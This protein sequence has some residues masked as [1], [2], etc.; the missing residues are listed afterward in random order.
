MTGQRDEE[1]KQIITDGMNLPYLISSYGRVI[2]VNYRG[3]EFNPKEMRTRIGARGYLHVSLSHH[4]A[5]KTFLVHRL[6][7]EAFI[8]NPENKPIVN[9]ID[10]VPHHCFIWNLEWVTASENT[11]HAFSIGRMKVRRGEEIGDNKFTTPM[12]RR[13][14]ELLS[15]GTHT[16]LEISKTTG[17]SRDMV[18]HIL[19]GNFWKHIS[20]DYDFSA[21]WNGIGKRS[22]TKI[23]T[24]CKMMENGCTLYEISDKT[25]LSYSMIHKISTGERC[26]SISKDYK[27]SNFKK[28]HKVH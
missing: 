20:C 16:I 23:V 24:A 3:I 26:S 12:V 10:A 6:L 27:I 11:R 8:S 5:I 13:V 17:V 21:Y 25:G 14:C 15:D 4:G 1:F 18:R 2:S 28:L 9:H 7:A 22:L 19:N